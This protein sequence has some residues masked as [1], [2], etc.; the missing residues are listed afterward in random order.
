MEDAPDEEAEE[1]PMS[2]DKISNGVNSGIPSSVDKKKVYKKDVIYQERSK[3]QK[4]VK[5]ITWAASIILVVISVL[6][7]TRALKPI[8]FS[9]DDWILIT[10]LKI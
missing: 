1:Y 9:E 8:P 2:M 3:K 4:N 5:R 7:S 6:I 10:T